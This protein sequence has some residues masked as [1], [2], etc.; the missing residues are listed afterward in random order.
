MTET[1]ADDT[2]DVLK[3]LEICREIE[4][5]CADLYR[6][7]SQLFIDV[8]EQ[9]ALWRK[10]SLEEENHANQFAL[11]Q[12]LS[13]HGTI[14]DMN[15]GLREAQGAL[16]LVQSLLE[17]A[18][19]AKPSILAALETSIALEERLAAFHTTTVANFSS[20]SIARMFQAM[21]HTD[22]EHIGALRELREKLVKGS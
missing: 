16:R 5:N 7:Y 10:T 17:K 14:K 9:S 8:P 13:R 20:D 3:I 1:N 22:D 12:S 11:A 18:R 15:A 6:F 21:M 2:S 19:T 4:L